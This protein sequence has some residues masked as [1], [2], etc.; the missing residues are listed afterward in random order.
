MNTILP[1]ILGIYII[2]F[3][4]RYFVI[5]EL[6]TKKLLPN[7]L[8]ENAITFIKMKDGSKSKSAQSL[9]KKYNLI[10]A[11]LWGVTLVVLIVVIADNIGRL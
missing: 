2:L 8:K 9:Y 6:N 11:F 10:T 7:N 3:A 5:K 4:I 1:I